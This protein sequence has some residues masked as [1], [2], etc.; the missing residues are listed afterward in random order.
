MHLEQQ[1]ASWLSNVTKGWWE[2]KRWRSRN[3]ASEQELLHVNAVVA[4][5]FVA[6]I[7]VGGIESLSLG[8]DG[9]V[10][11][12]P[13]ERVV[14]DRVVAWADFYCGD[15]RRLRESRRDDKNL[16][17]VHHV[18]FVGEWLGHAQDEVGLSDL[19]SLREIRKSR[20]VGRISFRHSIGNPRAD[21]GLLLVRQKPLAAQRAVVVVRSPRRHV[22]GLRDVLD[23]VAVSC[24]FRVRCERHGTNFTCAMTL[25]AFGVNDGSDVR[26]KG[27]RRL[28]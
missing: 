15:F 26:V 13:D 3:P 12:V 23:E 28:G 20:V 25:G 11:S 2:F 10:V 14:I 17:L 6:W 21:E 8:N 4:K 9:R 19:A 7:G 22:V 27:H 16:V 5:A 24:H 18:A 1:V